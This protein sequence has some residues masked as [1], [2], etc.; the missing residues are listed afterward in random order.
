[1]HHDILSLKKDICNSLDARTKTTYISGTEAVLDDGFPPYI[2]PTVSCNGSLAHSF[3]LVHL[4]PDMWAGVISTIA[5]IMVITITHPYS[6]LEAEKW[7]QSSVVIQRWPVN[8]C[9]I[10]F[11]HL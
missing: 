7:S 10:F 6:T 4:I 8:S 11:N 3:Y 9:C 5:V 1:M 2:P